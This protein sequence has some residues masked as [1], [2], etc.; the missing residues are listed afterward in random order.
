MSDAS[1]QASALKRIA[2]LVQI[3]LWGA[4]LCSYKTADGVERRSPLG[5]RE[6]RLGIF[7][8]PG[9]IFDGKKA[10]R[11][12]V[13]LVFPQFGQ[14]DKAMAQHGFARSSTWSVGAVVD[15]AEGSTAVLSL[16]DS[17]ATRAVWNHSFRLEYV[18]SLTAA[19]RLGRAAS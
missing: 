7:V 17:E 19:G 10:I 6:P 16:T 1:A 13:P 8:S 4:T 9:A 15:D 5:S 12:G 3:Y 18:V 11:G 2:F 14:P